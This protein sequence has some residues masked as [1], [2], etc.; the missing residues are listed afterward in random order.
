MCPGKLF[1][2]EH[3]HGFEFWK[4]FLERVETQIILR[5]VQTQAILFLNSMLE[6]VG[7]DIQRR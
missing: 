7:S 1:L 5:V 4:F 6:R 2:S 3:N